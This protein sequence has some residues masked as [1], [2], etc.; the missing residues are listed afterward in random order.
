M[1]PIVADVLLET[2][3]LH[4]VVLP[5]RPSSFGLQVTKPGR[6]VT[7]TLRDSR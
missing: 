3:G 7:T 5:I 4:T 1:G 2:D 6:H